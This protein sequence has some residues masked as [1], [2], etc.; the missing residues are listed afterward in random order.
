MVIK[1]NQHALLTD[2]L[3]LFNRRPAPGQD[4]RRVETVNKG[5]GRVETRTLYAST[6]LNDYLDWPYVG[7]ALCL[8]TEVLSLK[9]GEVTCQRRYALSSLTPDQLGLSTLLTRWRGHWSIENNL[10]W[11]R[12]V[13]MNEDRARVRSGSLPHALATLR[14][15]TISILKL[16]GYH[17]IKDARFRLAL[18][19][20]TA[21]SIVCD[22]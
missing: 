8:E 2:L 15:T 13:L 3:T 10:H 7:Q 20:H 14:N 19:L 5:H 9:S 17:S 16:L 21:Y 18:D 1:D 22:P 12:D 6:D 4:L 11:T